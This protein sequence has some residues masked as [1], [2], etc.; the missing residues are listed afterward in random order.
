MTTRLY[1]VFSEDDEVAGLGDV[2]DCGDGS[3]A[4]AAERLLSAHR[5]ARRVEIWQGE[6]LLATAG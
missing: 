1:L 2:S 6:R 3:A 4:H 5:D